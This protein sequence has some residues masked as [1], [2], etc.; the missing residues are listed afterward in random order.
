MLRQ[1]ILLLIA[2]V[3]LLV[4][5]CNN[6][7][8]IDEP[9]VTDETI[10]VKVEGDD[11]EAVFTVSTKNLENISFDLFS[12]SRQYCTYYNAA[13]DII[14]PD[15]PAGQVSRIV[16]EN[17]FQKFE[18]LCKGTQFTF[19]SICNT[20]GYGSIT[21]RLEY[22]YGPR[23]IDISFTP[24]RPLQLIDVSY[25]G[26]LTVTEQVKSSRLSVVNTGDKELPFEIHPYLNE[27][28][29][30]LVTPVQSQSWVKGKTFDMNVPVYKGDRWTIS[31][32]KG[33]TPGTRLTYNGPDRSTCVTLTSPPRSDLSVWTDV[34]YSVAEAKGYMTF[35]N[36]ILGRRFTVDITA[37]SYYPVSYD[38]RIEDAN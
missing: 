16:F 18:L 22:T 8:F 31:E 28:A 5:G 15:A 7:V 4:A 17:D 35:L 6:D 11:D 34:T 33:I 19:R 3:G 13:G 36:E 20:G 24:G 21:L 26:P 12:E 9:D 25:S 29:A 10:S 37:K 30:I 14:A 38:I 27:V 32:V 2:A 1:Y 23:F